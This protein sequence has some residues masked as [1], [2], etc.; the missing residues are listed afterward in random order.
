MTTKE[1]GSEGTTA[2][3]L[4]QWRAAERLSA[5]AGKGKVAADEAA[6]AAEAAAD[7][8]HET[9]EAAKLAL[10]AA[11]RA[12]TSAAKTDVAARVVVQHSHADLAGA[13]LEAA[14]A[15]VDEAEARAR[16]RDAAERA[17]ESV[18]NLAKKG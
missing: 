17:F 11:T 10:E 7:A 16:Y 4:Q 1:P 9:A 18:G 12:E 15:N 3:T 6:T 2:A 14:T 13:V 8:A 5:V